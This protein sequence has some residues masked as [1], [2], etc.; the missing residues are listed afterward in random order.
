ME[1]LDGTTLKHRIAA[2]P[3]DI[4]ALLSLGG[5]IADGLDAAHSAGIVHRDI[6]PA[7]IFVTCRGH[8][9]ILD[10]GLA[11]VDAA[12]GHRAG[13]GTGAGATAQPTV[14]VE[15]Q[16]TNPGSALGTVPYMSPEQVRAQPLDA[17]TDLFS[18]GVVLYE[19]ATGKLPFLGESP[20]FD[21][22]LNRDPVP[23]VRLNPGVPAELERIIDKCLEKD[24]NLRYQH[25][26]EIGADL[27]RLKRD[28]GQPPGS[29]R[30]TTAPQPGAAAAIAKRWRYSYL[31]D[32]RSPM[33]QPQLTGVIRFGVFELE[34]QAGILRKH[35]V[36]VRL[37][38]QPFRVL[39]ALLE[40]PGDVVSR[41]ELQQKV[42]AGATFGDFDHSLNIAVN[43]IREALRDSA[44]TPRFVETLPRRGY[45]FIYPVQAE[46]KQP[47]DAAH[48][49]APVAVSQRPARRRWIW[50]AAGVGSAMLAVGFAWLFNNARHDAVVPYQEIP[51]T[52]LTGFV[53]SPSF[54]PDGK[55]I[56][57][58]WR[59]E[60]SG[61]NASIYVKLVGAGYAL[62]LTDAQAADACPAWSP[63]G[64]WV[65]FWRYLPPSSGIYVV[66]ALGGPARRIT[67][68]KAKCYGL[69][70]LANGQRLVLSE[71]PD[72]FSARLT[73]VNVDTGQQ[74]P[75]APPPAGFIADTSPAV[76]PDGK[77]LAFVRWTGDEVGNIRLR[78]IDGGADRWLA[79]GG[80]SSREDSIAWMPDGREIVF[81]RNGRLWRI[82]VTG[83]APQAVTSSAEW[84]K[85]P[86]VARRGS[87]LA[88][89]AREYRA[90]LWRIDLTGATPP[91][92]KQPVRLENTTGGHWDPAYS[93]DGSRFAFGANRS[94]LGE[95]WVDDA[96]A[97]GAVQLTKLESYS[98]SPRWSPDGSWI[99][100]DSRLNG[101]PDIFAVRPDG[102]KP[103]RITT[104]PAEDVVPGWSRDG[105]WIYF[106][107]LRSGE[108][109][110][111]KLPADTGESSS[112]PAVQVTQAGGIFPFESANGKYL[113]YS[114]G[115]GK[116]GLWRKDLAVPHGREEPVLESLQHWGWWSL[117][118]QGVFFLE[119][120][121]SPRPANVRLKFLDLASQ[122][123]T[124]LATLEKPVE[125][126]ERGI[127]VS[128]DGRHLLFTQMDREGSDIMLIEN[129]R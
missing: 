88:F 27:Q 57:Y 126:T 85:N 35:G 12:P 127:C 66:S 125:T 37:Q 5:E 49:S 97:R 4:E 43:K 14:T 115:R 48:A 1:F 38:E 92:A 89:V 84:M 19:M 18:F 42:W 61:S 67:A 123:I 26:S 129:F 82:P 6:K 9:K 119:Q 101:N 21:G 65:A 52:S 91:T 70:W 34:P 11:K 63:D 64:Q 90:S 110:I 106:T 16:S 3:L 69:D 47:P 103:R 56:A 46:V 83:G 76:S 114:K 51:L 17:R 60:G 107:S 68:L 87:R 94:L 128:P 39:L 24:R 109:Q 8:A 28:T 7:N 72:S 62:R 120:P 100:F 10:F 36:R 40:K 98:G 74:Q 77:T 15:D 20:V 102:G 116:I 32:Q 44:E 104:H 117:A 121:E 75:L 124:D 105:K 71:G 58:A 33:P 80:T 95:I 79:A 59:D 81:S 118:P 53:T 73:F 96:Q 99:A 93:P 2:R 41:E 13:P 55:Q 30:V 29:G 45:R 113:Y 50:L 122:R 22:I 112:T 108:Q 25:A 78:P 54:S 86:A 31:Q 111:W 23:P